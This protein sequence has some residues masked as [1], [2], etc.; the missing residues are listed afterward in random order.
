MKRLVHWIAST[1]DKKVG[2]VIASYSP[3]TSCPDSCSLKTGGC[4]AWGLF[5]IKKISDKL[6]DNA[7][8]PQSL[9]SVINRRSVS[10][11]IARHRIAGDI[12][13]DVPETLQECN[14]IGK[15]G[16]INIGYTHHWKSEEAAPLKPYF[17]ASCQSIEETMEARQKGWAATL[18]VPKGTAKR[19]VLPNGEIAFR[20]PAQNP[21]AHVTCN[22]CTLCKVSPKTESKTVMFEAHG[23]RATLKKL[24]EKL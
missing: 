6:I 17:R 5:Y 9:Q 12:V 23:N 7:T 19:I 20:C 1:K 11:R 10:C 2:E 24:N 21:G 14:E 8:Q 15:A 18:I 4:Y 13:N 22:M 16:L 3:I